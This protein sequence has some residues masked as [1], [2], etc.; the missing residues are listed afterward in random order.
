MLHALIAL[1]LG[2]EPREPITI[3][4]DEAP[5]ELERQAP[6]LQSWL[7]EHPGILVEL[8]VHTDTSGS[9]AY[10]QRISTE[11]AVDL[12]RQLTDAGVSP[13]LVVARGMG[14]SAPIKEPDT[15]PGNRRVVLIFRPE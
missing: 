8:Q 2:Q 6:E 10:N 5:A 13:S 12:K 7:Q 1:A 4:I 9:Q 3:P 15:D 14:E 11:R